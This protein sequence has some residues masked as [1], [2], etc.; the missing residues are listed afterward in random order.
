MYVIATYHSCLYHV[1]MSIML[2]KVIMLK[3][4]ICSIQLNPPDSPP[5]PIANMIVSDSQIRLG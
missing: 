4:L 5:A 3:K 2:P 1:L